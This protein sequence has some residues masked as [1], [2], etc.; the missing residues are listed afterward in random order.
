MGQNQTS[1][2]RRRHRVSG[3]RHVCSWMLNGAVN[4]TT[5]DILSIQIRLSL[6]TGTVWTYQRFC[7]RHFELYANGINIGAASA[8]GWN[9]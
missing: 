2:G 5:M 3:R 1:S 8:V 4:T 6:Q 9:R 7:R